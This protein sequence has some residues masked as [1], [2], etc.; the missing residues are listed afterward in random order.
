MTVPVWP[1]A[2][3]RPM[4]DEYQVQMQD[5]R[6]PQP[7]EV[8]PMGFRRQY[9][10]V[11]TDVRMKID[12][13]RNEKAIFEQFF[14]HDTRRG[15]LAFWMPDPT[16]DGWPMLT[17]SGAPLLDHSGAPMLLAAR[18]LC[19]FAQALPVETVIGNRFR[20]TFSVLVMP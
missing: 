3:P 15:A 12:V 17:G 1:G 11:A 19:L 8:G 10:S 2:L 13:S 20:K 18:W 9:S 5:A 6:L 16:T 4:R 7:P 14:I